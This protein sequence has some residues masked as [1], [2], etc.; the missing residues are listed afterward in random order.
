MINP[1]ALSLVCGGVTAPLH[2]FEFRPSALQGAQPDGHSGT[3]VAA[4]PNVPSQAIR[5]GARPANIANF[6]SIRIPQ[7]IY[8]GIRFWRVTVLVSHFS[9]SSVDRIWLGVTRCFRHCATP[10]L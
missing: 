7:A 3:V 10:Q 4:V 5:R 8:V 6:I 2:N 1:V 9:V